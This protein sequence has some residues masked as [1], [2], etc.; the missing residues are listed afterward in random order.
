MFSQHITTPAIEK[1][2]AGGLHFVRCRAKDV[3]SKKAK[4]AVLDEV[5]KACISFPH[6]VYFLHE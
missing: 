4:S 5:E 1:L 3:G 2:H 6:V